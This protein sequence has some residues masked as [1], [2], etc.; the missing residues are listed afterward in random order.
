MSL[1]LWKGALQLS[2]G[3]SRDVE[4]GR[5]EAESWSP[6]PM[7]PARLPLWGLRWEL[8]LSGT[9]E[10]INRSTT[11]QAMAHLLLFLVCFETVK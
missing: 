9:R 11:P 8:E 5:Q 1:T 7:L 6:S 3:W 2:G 10:V 4:W